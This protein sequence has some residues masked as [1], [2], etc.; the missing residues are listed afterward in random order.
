MPAL[1]Y[2]LAAA[3]DPLPGIYS[4]AAGRADALVFDFT[5]NRAINRDPVTPAENYNGTVDL[6]PTLTDVHPQTN[7]VL[8]T[9]T[10]VWEPYAANVKV[11]K[12]GVGL[13]SSEQ[14]TNYVRSSWNFSSANWAKTNTTAAVAGAEVA[15]V[16]GESVYSLTRTSTVANGSS[17]GLIG[18]GNAVV[19]EH[20]ILHAKVKKKSAG[21]MVALRIQGTYP[22]R[23]DAVFN[24][25]TTCT[26]E[27][28]AGSTYTNAN[29]HIFS[30]PDV[31]GYYHVGVS[32]TITGSDALSVV[33][34][35]TDIGN[36]VWEGPRPV[37]SDCYIKEVQCEKGAH[38]PPN[39]FPSPYIPNDSG[40]HT[41]R[42]GNLVNLILTAGR[43]SAGI[44]GWVKTNVT[45]SPINGFIANMRSV[46]TGNADRAGFV[47]SSATSNL[48]MQAFVGSVSQASVIL[49]T[50]P[51]IGQQ[52]L[53]FAAGPNYFK[54]RQVGQSAASD[55]SGFYPSDLGLLSLGSGGTGTTGAITQQLQKAGFYGG[56]VND[57]VFDE[58][59][60]IAAAA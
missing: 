15:S 51:T 30:G 47:I 55:L 26:V 18:A 37:L 22:N 33:V 34:G 57:A 17:S 54:A 41:T 43:Y 58:I 20:I 42:T 10:G 56:A 12:D 59:Y 4:L 23:V 28:I 3:P 44:A 2:G 16:A 1:N 35:P 48:T 11:R 19:G 36:N 25:T 40:A 29:A 53:V 32:C 21:N 7:Y 8:N 6:F 46:T 5:L 24:L 45:S 39:V 50:P 60:N 14:R 49:K 27:Y 38:A 52:T 31:N 13:Q 9:A